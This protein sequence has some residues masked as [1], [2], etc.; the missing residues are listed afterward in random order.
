MPSW[1]Q[2]MVPVLRALANQESRQRREVF[3]FAADE[4]GLTPEQR[5]EAGTSSQAKCQNRVG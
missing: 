2:C 4:L 3:E 5:L 1:D